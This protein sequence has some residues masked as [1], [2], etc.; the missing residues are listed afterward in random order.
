M[1]TTRNVQKRTAWVYAANE[2]EANERA[3]GRYYY[4]SWPSKN[5]ALADKERCVGVGEE[6]YEVEVTITQEFSCKK[7]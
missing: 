3:S 4:Q 2:K 7:A 6:L 1:L 5:S